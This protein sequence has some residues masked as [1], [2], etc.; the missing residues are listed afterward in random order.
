MKPLLIIIVFI[1]IASCSSQN[2]E[3]NIVGTWKTQPCVAH[4]E[5]SGLWL[6]A[7]YEFTTE[8][9]IT[10]QS[11]GFTDSDCVTPINPDHYIYGFPYNAIYTSTGAGITPDGL[12]GIGIVIQITGPTNEIAS[13]EGYYT[14]TNN[15]L[16]FSNV[17]IFNANGYSINTEGN[18]NINFE[19]CLAKI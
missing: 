17:F 19:S 1:H 8:G 6:K 12:Q 16:C 5:L 18:K 4:S 9:S 7:T 11:N 15:T 13:S 3:S 10:Y 14:I 2:N